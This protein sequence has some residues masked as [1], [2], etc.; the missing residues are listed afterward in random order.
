M[1]E[2]IERFKNLADVMKLAKLLCLKN[3][4]RRSR[5]NSGGFQTMKL[6]LL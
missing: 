2:N 3:L 1:T 6:L 4:G 5:E